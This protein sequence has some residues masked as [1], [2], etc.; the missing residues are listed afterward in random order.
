MN[1]E[2]I[3]F[4]DF[5]V[6]CKRNQQNGTLLMASCKWTVQS[7]LK[8]LTYLNSPG[9]KTSP[10][11]FTCTTKKLKT[12][13]IFLSAMIFLQTLALIY[14]TAPPNLYGMKLQWTWYPVVNGPKK[15]I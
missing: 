2:L 1:K 3:E 10:L 7:L 12:D 14:I 13:M 15:N 6:Y 9:S 5:D 8:I 4:A 11:P